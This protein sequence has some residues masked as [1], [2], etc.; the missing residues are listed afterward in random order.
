MS[1][2]WNP[3]WF[4]VTRPMVVRPAVSSPSQGRCECGIS[5]ERPLCRRLGVG[6]A[7]LPLASTHEHPIGSKWDGSSPVS[8]LGPT[9]PNPA[10]R[11]ET[12]RAR[13]SALTEEALPGDRALE[14][15]H[16]EG[17]KSETQKDAV[18][19]GRHNPVYPRVRN[20]DG[21]IDCQWRDLSPRTRGSHEG[22]GRRAVRSQSGDTVPCALSR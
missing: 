5:F 18:L 22:T 1:V 15:G 8:T 2:S 11:K 7:E 16:T 13:P 3:S 19:M 17:R 14:Q 20:G 12:R 10:L 21:K 6:S 9:T 4:P